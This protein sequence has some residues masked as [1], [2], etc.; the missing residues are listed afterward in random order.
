VVWAEAMS[1]IEP[2]EAKAAMMEAAVIS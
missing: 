2:I 1:G